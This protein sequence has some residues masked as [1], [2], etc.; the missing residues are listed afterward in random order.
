MDFIPPWWDDWMF[1]LYHKA[2]SER[3]QYIKE[4]KWLRCGKF[5]RKHH[6]FFVRRAR[7]LKGI[8]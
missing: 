7:Q 5:K 8:L 2:A 1:A 3:E 6:R 4:A